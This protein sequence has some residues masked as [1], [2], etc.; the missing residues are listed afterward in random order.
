MK[1][2]L[3]QFA[4]D[5]HFD[6]EFGGTVIPDI[7]PE[8]FEKELFLR[9]STLKQGYAPFCKLMFVENWTKAKTGTIKITDQNRR[10]LKSGYK[11]RTENELPVLSR[12][13]ENVSVSIAYYL[14][15]VLYDREQLK[16]E[17]T[18]IDADY[19]I[20]AILGQNYNKEEPMTPLTMM[21]N[22]LG[23]IE[24]GSGVKIDRE[25]YLQSVAF[26]N[27][28]AIVKGE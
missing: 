11:A 25:K 17:G 3:T 22:A 5:R 15:I 7:T 1:I 8:Q 14:C 16:K 12:W 10:F 4:I 24:G 19:G 6:P 18:N 2:K 28:H 9:S 27:D 23:I 21:R 20:V 26:W 13:F